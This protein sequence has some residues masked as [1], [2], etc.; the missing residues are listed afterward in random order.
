MLK[1][2]GS[3]QKGGQFRVPRVAAQV[4]LLCRQAGSES[5]NMTTLRIA[6]CTLLVQSSLQSRRT[7]SV[8]TQ[9][10]LALTRLQI[11][12]RQTCSY[13]RCCIS[14]LHGAAEV[15]K[16]AKRVYIGYKQAQT[17]RRDCAEEQ[18]RT[19]MASAVVAAT[20]LLRVLRA[21]VWLQAMAFLALC[22]ATAV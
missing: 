20:V 18:N 7:L 21:L 8:L 22:P 15:W 3:L 9:Q 13:A 19:A 11:W 1:A 2:A 17:K 5:I 10:F 16:P 4:S 6:S 14:F 12:C